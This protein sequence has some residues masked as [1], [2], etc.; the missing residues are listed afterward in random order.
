MSKETSDGPYREEF[1]RWLDTATK[2]LCAEAKE[3]I[4]QEIEAHYAEAVDTLREEGMT[5][6]DA[7]AR[8]LASLGSPRKAARAFR[9]THLTER[10]ANRLQRILSQESLKVD[11]SDMSAS[12]FMLM[13]YP[14]IVLGVLVACFL[15]YSQG[16]LAIGAG[17]SLL[18]VVLFFV[19]VKCLIYVARRRRQR[20]NALPRRQVVQ[21]TVFWYAIAFLTN[22]LVLWTLCVLGLPYGSHP[23]GA[24]VVVSFREGVL[25]LACASALVLFWMYLSLWLKLRRG[26]DF[27]DPR[28]RPG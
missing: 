13:F 7:H 8:V 3:R 10:E 23:H 22:G 26:A 12:M 19:M 24:I 15:A 17:V 14:F 1:E 27:T 11:W 25:F 28:G 4:G 6:Q 20:A 2:S 9:R 16:A 18:A 21:E 5:E